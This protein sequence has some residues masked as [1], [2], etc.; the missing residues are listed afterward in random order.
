MSACAGR[1]VSD[2]SVAKYIEPALRAHYGQPAASYHVVVVAHGIFNYE[3]MGALL[4]RRPE[5]IEKNWTYRGMT[6]VSDCLPL[7]DMQTGWNRYEIGYIGE[8]SASRIPLA[9]LPALPPLEVD[10]M[11]LDVTAHL[12][13]IKRQRGGIGSAGFDDK[14]Q[15]IK[16]F[17]SGA[18]E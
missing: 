8:Q 16:K 3:L 11:A 7:A 2:R 18:Q 13:G 4:A 5:G 17:L 12:D 14:Q 1:T 15:S 6:N 10:T 9:Q